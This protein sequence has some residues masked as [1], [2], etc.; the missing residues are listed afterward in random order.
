MASIQSLLED[1][2]NWSNLQDWK[3]QK[4]REEMFGG[5]YQLAEDVS[6]WGGGF[7]PSNIGAGL[8]GLAGTLIGKDAAIR[9]GKQEAFDIADEMRKAGKSG[10][11]IWRDTLVMEHPTTKVPLMGISDAPAKFLGPQVR[12]NAMEQAQKKLDELNA[13]KQKYPQDNVDLDVAAQKSKLSDAME[14]Y[15]SGSLTDFLEHPEFFKAYP[16]SKNLFNVEVS[17][18]LSGLGEYR[19]YQTDIP[20]IGLR[21]D[22]ALNE[23]LAPNEKGLSALMH[24]LTH[25]GSHMEGRP[26]G[27]SPEMM[28]PAYM[29]RAAQAEMAPHILGQHEYNQLW[30]Q[31]EYNSALQRAQKYAE[32]S[33]REGLRPSAIHRLSDWYKYSDDIRSEL[34]AMPKKPGAQRDFWM[35]RAFNELAQKAKLEGSEL[36]GSD[37]G[38]QLESRSLRDLLNE[39][40]RLERQRLKYLP[41]AQEAGLIERKFKRLGQMGQHDR[42][43]R[44]ADEALA[45]QV[46][47]MLPMTEAEMRQNYPMLN[48]E[49]GDVPVI[50]LITNWR[51]GVVRR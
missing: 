23:R 41:A 37:F 29:E 50:D 22:V 12:L 45:R 46:Q 42:Y 43:E 47:K 13:W 25:Y 32:M 2:K 18:T 31:S 35:R 8:G 14:G 40:K 21:S 19:G 51:R 34:G 33:Q 39:G 28:T 11:D 6:T 30:K 44:L 26:S 16:Q 27:G 48:D 15:F 49:I 38:R 5:D 24:E 17:P 20:E 1:W 3:L 7:N 36:Y 4:Q 10:K 9:L